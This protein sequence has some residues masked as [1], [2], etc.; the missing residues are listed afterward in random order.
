MLPTA[1]SKLYALTFDYATVSVPRSPF[2]AGPRL[3]SCEPVCS[4]TSI[5]D[6]D[7]FLPIVGTSVRGQEYQRYSEAV[8][9]SSLKDVS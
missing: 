5:G 7:T 3:N 6:A 1:V 8:S 2:S 4:P 9:S